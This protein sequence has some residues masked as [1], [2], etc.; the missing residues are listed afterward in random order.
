MTGHTARIQNVRHKYCNGPPQAARL[1]VT[2]LPT[3]IDEHE[4]IPRIY[5]GIGADLVNRSYNSIQSHTPHLLKSYNHETHIRLTK[6][7]CCTM[8]SPLRFFSI[9]TYFVKFNIRVSVLECLTQKTSSLQASTSK[10]IDTNRGNT[11]VQLPT[12]ITKRRI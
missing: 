5:G 3:F 12:A 4:S 11:C 6:I 10:N 7:T 9:R 2:I 1:S 8:C